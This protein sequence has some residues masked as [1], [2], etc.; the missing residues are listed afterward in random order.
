MINILFT[1]ILSIASLNASLP[2]YFE[3]MQSAADYLFS[4]DI[5]YSISRKHPDSFNIESIE[6]IQFNFDI[7]IHSSE[8]IGRQKVFTFFN[9]LFKAITSTN[10]L[11]QER[12]EVYDRLTELWIEENGISYIIEE[13]HYGLF[14][15]QRSPLFTLNYETKLRVMLELE[16][17]EGLDRE[18][19]TTA[20]GVFNRMREGERLLNRSSIVSYR[21]H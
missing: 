8:A 3:S 4:N 18:E 21:H 20:L 1:I 7:N 17:Q 15:S 11:A 6:R 9:S 5:Y 10:Q 14:L 19:F 12:H 2:S 16:D 13:L